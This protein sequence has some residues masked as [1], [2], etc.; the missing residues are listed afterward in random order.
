MSFNDKKS[1]N[2]EFKTFN[3]NIIILIIQIDKTQLLKIKFFGQTKFRTIN[4]KCVI[5]CDFKID[6]ETIL[7][8]YKT[9]HRVHAS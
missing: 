1:V 9:I 3:W 4:K 6:P 5:R 2:N 7:K 8:S